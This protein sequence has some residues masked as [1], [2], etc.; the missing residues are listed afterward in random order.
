MTAVGTVTAA[1]AVPEAVPAVRA[2]GDCRPLPRKVLLHMGLQVL[3]I[4]EW[5]GY[6]TRAKIYSIAAANCPIHHRSRL[7][8]FSIAILSSDRVETRIWCGPRHPWLESHLGRDRV[9][10]V[11]AVSSPAIGANPRKILRLPT[12]R[13]HTTIER[14]RGTGIKT[15]IAM[16]RVTC[17]VSLR[18]YVVAASVASQIEIKELLWSSRTEQT[19]AQ[20][21]EGG[22]EQTFYGRFLKTLKMFQ[23]IMMRHM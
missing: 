18:M 5:A 19:R 1:G 16:R 20:Q 11:W 4:P 21:S 23:A 22:P 2:E 9:Q 17:R 14:N 3:R 6:C 13:R 10:V 8:T 7:T 12:I 15:L